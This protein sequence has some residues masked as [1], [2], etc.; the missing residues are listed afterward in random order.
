[1]RNF[2]VPLKIN[3]KMEYACVL[4]ELFC[5]LFVTNSNLIGTNSWSIVNEYSSK[6][7]IFHVQTK[8]K[9]RLFQQFIVTEGKSQIKFYKIVERYFRVNNYYGL[10]DFS[11]VKLT[12][13]TLTCNGWKE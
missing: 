6:K 3:A 4:F 12:S 5:R 9:E 1:M 13:P 8:K 7:A 2:P 10:C 11:N